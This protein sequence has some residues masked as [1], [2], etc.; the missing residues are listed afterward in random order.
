LRQAEAR[1]D[2]GWRSGALDG[3]DGDATTMLRS[4]VMRRG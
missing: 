3:G 2:Q 4:S 1:R